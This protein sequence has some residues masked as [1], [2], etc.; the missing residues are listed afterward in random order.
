MQDAD[1]WELRTKIKNALLTF[2]YFHTPNRLSGRFLNRLVDLPE[3]ASPPIE[4]FGL[5]A[6]AT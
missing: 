6:P 5:P 1:K 3:D 2:T 4:L